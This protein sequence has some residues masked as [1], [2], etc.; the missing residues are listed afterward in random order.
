MNGDE[1]AR[2]LDELNKPGTDLHRSY[3]RWKS[4]KM[5]KLI[6]GILYDLSTP[7]KCAGKLT[8]IPGT[9]N[10]SACAMLGYVLGRSHAV[11]EMMQLDG[12]IGQEVE[13][14]TET[15]NEGEING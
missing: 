13:D 2:Y 3:V 1:V 11:T 9:G 7:D 14:I 10:D 5:T 4:S 12:L 15:F 6:T 8:N